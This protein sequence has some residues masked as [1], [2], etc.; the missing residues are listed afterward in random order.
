MIEYDQWVNAF[1]LSGTS[2][3]EA[4][5]KDRVE[6]ASKL[7]AWQWWQTFGKR[8]PH[9][10]WFAMRLTA[11]VC[12]ACACERNWSLYEWIHNRKRNSL[13]VARA[14]KLVRSHCNL[15]SSTGTTL[16]PP[17]SCR[18]WTRWSSTTQRG[19]SMSATQR[20]TRP[21]PHPWV[22]ARSHGARAR[23]CLRLG[24]RPKEDVG[25]AVT[26]AAVDVAVLPVLTPIS[27]AS[28]RH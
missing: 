14:E 16:P 25:A 28:T 2:S 6:Q 3:K 13:S 4:L 22:C 17:T 18:G 8:W 26:E 20:M 9:L 1:K 19:S 11:Q 23:D 10:R 27:L 15:T 21:R 12:S 5:S 7:P 24:S